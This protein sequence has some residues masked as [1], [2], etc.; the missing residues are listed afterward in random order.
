MSLPN[1][2]LRKL[3][4]E[5]ESQALFSQ[6]QLSIVK[7]QMAA[8]QRD[9]RLLQL[10]STELATL[11]KETRVYEG[12]GKMFVLEDLKAVQN[13]LASEKSELE[14]DIKNLEKKFHYLETTFNN[15]QASLNQILSGGR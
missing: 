13:R 4:Q 1:E 8:K 9:I 6:Q 3:M 7:S 2:A 11:P 12:V 14:S 15:A 5:I 10:T